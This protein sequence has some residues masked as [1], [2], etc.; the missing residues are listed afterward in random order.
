M[1]WFLRR[2]ARSLSHIW[3]ST[4]RSGHMRGISRSGI[5]WLWCLR[6]H[7]RRVVHRL[8]LGRVSESRDGGMRD[9]ADVLAHLAIVASLLGRGVH[10]T[11]RRDEATIRCLYPAWRWGTVVVDL[12]GSTRN[13][14][15]RSTTWST[16]LG[17]HSRVQSLSGK[18][19]ANSGPAELSKHLFRVSVTETPLPPRL[20]S[21]ATAHVPP[22]LSQQLLVI[23]TATILHAREA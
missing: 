11:L 10:V 19:D 6:R 13:R 7:G 12:T 8:V 5:H 16:K 22:L 1:R 23:C 18:H 2:W 21:R 15:Q 14:L 9:N 20:E 4:V 17:C 3:R